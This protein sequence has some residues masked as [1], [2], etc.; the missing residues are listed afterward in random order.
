M[1]K[2]VCFVLLSILSLAAYGQKMGDLTAVR[3]NRADGESCQNF[4]DRLVKT[5]KRDCVMAHNT[6]RFQPASE[7]L[8]NSGPAFFKPCAERE[9]KTVSTTYRCEHKDLVLSPGKDIE[10]EA[11]KYT[12]DRSFKAFGEEKRSEL[13]AKDVCY[14][15]VADGQSMAE[16]VC[17]D[18]PVQFLVPLNDLRRQCMQYR[19]STLR[20]SFACDVTPRPQVEDPGKTIT[21]L[22]KGDPDKSAAQFKG[23]D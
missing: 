14:R 7:E 20:I 16:K 15:M 3:I 17:N 1:K 4:Y 12:S 19:P 8:L 10:L 5:I 9:F 21:I 23:I 6:D 18:V 13:F 2:A 22:I 11:S